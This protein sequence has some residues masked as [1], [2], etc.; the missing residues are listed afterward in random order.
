MIRSWLPILIWLLQTAA[1][2]AIASGK[3]V[4]DRV[5]NDTI[6]GR[7][8]VIHVVVALCD[9]KYQGIVPVPKGIGNGQ[10]PNTNLYWGAGFGV[11]T[12]FV[13]NKWK[14][15]KTDVQPTR[16]ILERIILFKEI[17]RN[18]HSSQVYLVADAWDGKEIQAATFKFLNIAA[19]NDNEFIY[20]INNGQKVTLS[21]GG[22]SHLVAYVGHDGLMDFNLPTNPTE[23]S[24]SPARSSI[25]L[26]CASLQ[27]FRPRLSVGGS[28]QLL[29]T[30]GLMAPEAYTLEAAIASW[31]DGRPSQE[32]LNSAAI[33]YNQFQKCGIHAAKNLFY[34][35]P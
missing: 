8:V 32:I 22:A 15:V 4:Q 18:M 33:A 21:I 24:K 14:I 34:T 23:N 7:P 13:N 27:F 9:N 31:L 3:A 16:H 10:N 20:F 26:A 30:T 11:R 25:V 29:L 28:H 1:P 2:P 35:T 5:S 12:F 17:K 6:K 19:G